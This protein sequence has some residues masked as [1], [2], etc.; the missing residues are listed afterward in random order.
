MNSRLKKIRTSL[1]LSQKDFVSKIYLSQDHISS[2]ENGRRCITDRTL[3]DICNQFDIN[4]E[5]LR[6]G[7]GE[8]KKEIVLNNNSPEDIKVLLEKFLSLNESAQKN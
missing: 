8:M 6:Y 4:E 5:W 7:T 2:L 3:K 1:G